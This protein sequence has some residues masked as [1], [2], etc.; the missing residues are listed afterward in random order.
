MIVNGSGHA[1]DTKNVLVSIS[2][3]KQYGHIRK[4]IDVRS[5]VLR[6]EA[7]FGFVIQSSQQV[8]RIQ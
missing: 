8:E 4:N 2:K 5:A 1:E 7:I 3:R 6:R